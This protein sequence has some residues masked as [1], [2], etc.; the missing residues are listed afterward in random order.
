M[1]LSDQRKPILH[2][3]PENEVLNMRRVIVCSIIVGLIM[4]LVFAHFLR[5]SNAEN[6]VQRTTTTA[7]QEHHT[8]HDIESSQPVQM[9]ELEIHTQ[10]PIIINNNNN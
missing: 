10:Q 1:L 4:G 7:H 8:F 3:M 6:L 2:Y 5:N 9:P